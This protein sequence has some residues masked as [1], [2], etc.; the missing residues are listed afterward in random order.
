VGCCNVDFE[1]QT[2]EELKKVTKI[3]IELRK[4]LKN[5]TAT[6]WQQK[7]MDKV[8]KDNAFNDKHPEF[9][10]SVCSLT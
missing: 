2:I 8:C 5:Q 3:E 9:C 6:E 7:E 10:A 4:F 1:E